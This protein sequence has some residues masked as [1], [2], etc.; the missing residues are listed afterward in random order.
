M[1]MDADDREFVATWTVRAIAFVLALFGA[2]ITLGL[3]WRVF[4][5]VKG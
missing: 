5:I 3:A 1:R 4:E 2:A